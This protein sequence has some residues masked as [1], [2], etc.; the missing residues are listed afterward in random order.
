MAKRDTIKV[1]AEA[2]K[3]KEV[4]LC[5]T[6]LIQIGSIQ[7]TIAGSGEPPRRSCINPDGEVGLSIALNGS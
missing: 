5:S 3:L 7:D 1:S 2:A 4:A 6:I